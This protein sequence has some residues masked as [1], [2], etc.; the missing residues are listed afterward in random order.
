LAEKKILY[1]MDFIRN[2][3]KI[4]IHDSQ[5]RQWIAKIAQ[6]TAISETEIRE[7]FD[8]MQNCREKGQITSE[9]LI[10]LNQKINEFRR[11]AL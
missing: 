11:K 10:A 7:M 1:C 6:K 4:P 8:A 9:E 3:L 2:H 5:D